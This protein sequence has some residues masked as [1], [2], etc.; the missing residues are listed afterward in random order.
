MRAVPVLSPFRGLRYAAPAVTDY[1]AVICPPYDVISPA[2]RAAL[3]A[4]SRVNAVHVELPASYDEAGRLFAAWQA[5][6]TLRRDEREMVYVYEQRYRLGDGPERTARGFMCRLRLEPTDSDSGVHA[7]EHTMSAPKEDRFRLMS[8]VRANLSPVIL[9]Y[10]AGADLPAA[11]LL[12]ELTAG[13]PDEEAVDDR[14]V[15]HRLWA[16]EPSMAPAAATLL[17]GAG[18][19]PLT[20]ADGHHRYATAVRYCADVGGAGSEAVLALLFEARTGDL[21]VLATHRLIKAPGLNVLERA[22]RAFSVAHVTSQADAVPGQ[23]GEIGLWTRHGAARLR[24]GTALAGSSPVAQ[25]D[26]SALATA[27]PAV[28]GATVDQLTAENR[29]SYT[30]DLAEAMRSVDAGEADAAF[31]LAPTPVASVIEVAAAGEVM[32]PKST[33]FYPK[34][35]TGLI[36]NPLVP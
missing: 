17:A 9:L 33:F 35:A 23:P 11:N 34:A 24:S 22:G 29:I 28:V 18:R 25:L 2:Q 30:Q 3:A 14:G 27:L 15:R 21:S 10:E 13:P 12:A 36:F 32:P 7:H 16:V 1:S 26:V 4:R 6:G 20:I 19:L 8:A 31:L 5:D